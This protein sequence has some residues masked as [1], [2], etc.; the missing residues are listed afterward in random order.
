[1]FVLSRLTPFDSV[2][3][4]V[5]GRQLLDNCLMRIMYKAGGELINANEYC[6]GGNGE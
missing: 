4:I 6:L 1:M 2:D 5:V 3:N